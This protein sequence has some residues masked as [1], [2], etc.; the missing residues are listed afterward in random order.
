MLL[1][2]KLQHAKGFKKFRAHCQK[3]VNR[4]EHGASYRTVQ[5]TATFVMMIMNMLDVEPSRTM[6]VSIDLTLPLFW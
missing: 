2:T 1:S 5:C 6:I 3:L 4:A